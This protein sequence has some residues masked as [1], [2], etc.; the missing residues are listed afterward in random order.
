MFGVVHPCP[1]PLME[2]SSNPLAASQTPGSGKDLKASSF[3]PY[4]LEKF[5]MRSL[6]GGHPLPG[7]VSESPALEMARYALSRKDTE[8]PSWTLRSDIDLAGVIPS[9]NLELPLGP[10]PAFWAHKAWRVPPL[11]QGLQTSGSCPTAQPPL[12]LHGPVNQHS[13]TLAQGGPPGEEAPAPLE[14]L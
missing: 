3:L 10:G 5:L 1:E 6:A 9:D 2:L 4:P 13:S 14:L 7:P 12:G 11:A 8:G